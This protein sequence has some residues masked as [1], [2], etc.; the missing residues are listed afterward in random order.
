[1]SYCC[2]EFAEQAGHLQPPAGGGLY[3]AFMRPTAQFVF[4]DDAWHVNGCCGGGCYVITDM[5][6]CP[7]CG[8]KLSS[9]EVLEPSY[10]R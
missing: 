2:E 8:A 4:E 5:K 9:P 6:F 1:M 3:P 7:Y 10:A